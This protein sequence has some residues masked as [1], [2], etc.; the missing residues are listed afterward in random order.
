MNGPGILFGFV[1]NMSIFIKRM[2]LLPL[3]LEKL[4]NRAIN[5]DT[6]QMDSTL[7]SPPFKY[8]RLR[9]RSNYR[10]EYNECVFLNP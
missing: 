4:F 9:V 5:N 2:Q 10:S 1:S 6:L 3:I 8:I 7:S